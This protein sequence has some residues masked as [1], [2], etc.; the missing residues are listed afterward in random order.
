MATNSNIEA[1][2]PQELRNNIAIKAPSDDVKDFFADFVLFKSVFISIPTTINS[3]TT[4]VK[5]FA[6]ADI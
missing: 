4:L 2:I 1:Q 5:S 6:K 3:V